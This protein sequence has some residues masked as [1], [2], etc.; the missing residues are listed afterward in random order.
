LLQKEIT[1]ESAPYS[2]NCNVLFN[3]P[4]YSRLHTLLLRCG[5]WFRNSNIIKTLLIPNSP[6]L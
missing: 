5:S 4:H 1:E 2:L 6:S 3:R